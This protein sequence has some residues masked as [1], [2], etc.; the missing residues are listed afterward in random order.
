MARAQAWLS[1]FD[2]WEPTD[3][4]E[5]AT[6]YTAADTHVF[7]VRTLENDPEGFGMVAVEAAAYGVPTIAY[8]TGGVVDAV[9]PGQSGCLV[10]PDDAVAFA[11]AV[12]RMLRQ[13]PPAAS[14]RAHA[15]R[16]AWPEF[17]RKLAQI[18]GP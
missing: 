5:I 13:P 16:F 7:P 12:C 9:E 14:I 18:I 1:T 6:I 10:E 8:A 17:G 11:A 2:F 15:A 4:D 3:R